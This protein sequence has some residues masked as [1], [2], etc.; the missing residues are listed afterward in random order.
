[1]ENLDENESLQN[2]KVTLVPLAEPVW[3]YKIWEWVAVHTPFQ[4][5]EHRYKPTVIRIQTVEDGHWFGNM[6][7]TKLVPPRII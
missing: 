1:M 3:I 4:L 7:I 5:A 2:D 6:P